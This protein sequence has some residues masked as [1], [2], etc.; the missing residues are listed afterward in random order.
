LTALSYIL[1]IPENAGAILKELQLLAGA[2]LCKRHTSRKIETETDL[3]EDVDFRYPNVF[4]LKTLSIKGVHRVCLH[5]LNG[6]KSFDERL[7]L[8]SST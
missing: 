6:S 4:K 2:I 5:M 7:T 8:P 3:K 1:P